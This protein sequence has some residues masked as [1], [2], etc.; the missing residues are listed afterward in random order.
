MGRNTSI[1]TSTT[2]NF[3]QL[4]DNMNNQSLDVGATGKLTTTVDSDIVGAINELDSNMGAK[5]SLTTTNKTSIVNAINEL[6]SDLGQLSTLAS[7]IRDSNFAVSI[8]KLN[9][10]VSQL[11]GSL[12]GLDSA[13]GDSDTR[14]GGFDVAEQVTVVSALNAISQDIQRLDSDINREARMT[15]TATTLRGA[16]NELDSDIGARPHTNLNTTAKNLVDAINENKASLNALAVFRNIATDSGSGSISVTVDSAN[17]TLSVLGGSS[18]KTLGIGGN[19]IQIDHDVTG[20]SSVNNSGNTFI[21]DLTIDANGHVTGTASSEAVIN[22]GTLTVEGGTNISGSGTFTANQSGDTTITLNNDIT[23]NNQLTNGANYITSSSVG[24]GTLSMSASGNLFGSATF[25]ANQS[26]S[27][28][29]SVGISATPTFTQ[30]FAQQYNNST[31]GYLSTSNST[32][33]NRAP[34]V[35]KEDRISGTNMW[36]SLVPSSGATH[37]TATLIRSGANG[38][39]HS[40]NYIYIGSGTYWVSAWCSLSRVAS[41]TAD[42]VSM[43][44]GKSDNLNGQYIIGSA[45]AIGDWSTSM[46][47][48]EGILS[49]AG[50]YAIRFYSNETIRYRYAAGGYPG[51]TYCTARIMAW[52][53]Y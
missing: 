13:G 40:G 26:G 39:S 22:N 10:N 52:K 43:W 24:N 11:L 25:T 28:S 27:S 46:F 38:T 32:Y 5:T 42:K 47:K 21:Q 44:I 15:T 19:K 37:P 31:V 3:T 8:N 36:S 4:V 17:D 16:I 35:W 6:D 29:F 50:Y 51:H 12:S 48:A 7:D 30:V 49:G 34:D 33:A 9:T 41:D 20:A 1:K 53:M 45:N 14:R 23:N 2:D 18:L